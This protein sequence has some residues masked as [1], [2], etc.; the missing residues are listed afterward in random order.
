MKIEIAN[1]QSAIALDE[2]R[3]TEEVRRAAADAGFAGELSVAVVTDPAIREINARFLGHDWET[4]VI[5]FPLGEE[6]GEVVVSAD[7]ALAESA[8]RGV[9][10]MAELLLYVIHGILHLMGHDDHEAEDARR[11]HELSL[12][13]LQGIGYRNTI[14]DCERDGKE[15]TS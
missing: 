13:L 5:A 1:T 11:M 8:A 14:P 2:A 3:F 9:E 7:R 6:E 15:R 10:P 12:R 4:D